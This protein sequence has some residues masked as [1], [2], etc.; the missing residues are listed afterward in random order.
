MRKS[1]HNGVTLSSTSSGISTECFPSEVVMLKKRDENRAMLEKEVTNEEVKKVLFSMPA[2]KSPGPD[3]YTSEF[4][5]SAWPLIENDFTV[6]IQSFFKK[7]FLPKGVN[8]T[9][10]ALIPKKENAQV[11]K[12]YRPISCCNVLY[13]VISKILANRLKDLLPQI[14]SSNQSAIVKDRLLMENVLLASELVKDY[15]KEDISP[16][17][18][19]K[20]DISKAFDSVQW[21]FLLNTLQALNFPESARGLRQGCALSPYLFVICMNVLSHLINK[22]AAEKKFGYHPRCQ[23]ILLTHL[24][25]ADDLMIF[26]EGTKRSVEG[27]ITI[28]DKFA[29]ISGL[30]IS[31]EKS[32]LY[33]A[34][35][36]QSTQEEILQNFPFEA[37]SLP[38][39]YLGLP[40]MTKAMTSNDYLPLIEKI[41]NII[42]TWTSR[43]LSYGG[44][45]Q[46][47]KSVLMSITNFWSSAFRFPGKCM[48]EVER[49]CS[50]FLWSGPDLKSHSA[51]IAW[52]VVCLPKGEGGA[53]VAED[54]GI[55][56]STVDVEL[57]YLPPD[58]SLDCPPVVMMNNRQVSNFLSYC[59]RKN[60]IKLCVTFNGGDKDTGSKENFDLNKEPDAASN[61]DDD[62]NVDDGDDDVNVDDISS[63][64][65]MKETRK[66]DD[67]FKTPKN[68]IVGHGVRLSSKYSCVSQGQYF[69]SKELLQSIMDCMR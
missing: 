37:V 2:N 9:I 33:M 48:K 47:I 4:F 19:M 7:G 55:E 58:L 41:R 50:A 68:V 27:V 11:M 6:A 32:T 5:K 35:I 64:W 36:Q 3:G 66:N 67:C 42:S 15:H 59:K 12:D 22:A 24:C 39:R 65:V 63:S 44:R 69:R 46:L 29:S 30:K 51:K 25:F 16:R 61:G 21:T 10:L 54:Y 60:T 26:A 23:N 17:C 1:S 31:L 45:L 57:S 56:Q 8:T 40:L 43:F 13:K 62:V 38:V 28:F 53:M 18:A 34:G 49:L 14:V 52:Q 20:I